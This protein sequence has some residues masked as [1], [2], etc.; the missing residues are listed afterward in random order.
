MWHFEARDFVAIVT[1]DPTAIPCTKTSSPPPARTRKSVPGNV[2]AIPAEEKRITAPRAGDTALLDVFGNQEFHSMRSCHSPARLAVL[3]VDADFLPAINW[4]SL[5]AGSCRHDPPDELVEALLARRVWQSPSSIPAPRRDRA[6][7]ARR[8][9]KARRSVVAEA[10]TV[11]GERRPAI[12]D[13]LH[14]GH[15]HRIFFGRAASHRYAL[16]VT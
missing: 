7:C 4:Q 5:R 16:G 8:R 11:R 13:V 2:T 14:F 12:R 15:Q 9:W 1:M 3:L 10:R 6:D